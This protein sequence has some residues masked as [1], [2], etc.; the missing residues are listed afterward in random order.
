MIINN[1]I[2]LSNKG[3]HVELHETR[4]YERHA[5]NTDTHTVTQMIEGDANNISD[6]T[7]IDHD[8]RLAER[9]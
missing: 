5:L 4:D 1:I 7:G 3:F 2:S 9:D 8:E 6:G